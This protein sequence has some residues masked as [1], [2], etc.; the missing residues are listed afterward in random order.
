MFKPKALHCDATHLAAVTI[1]HASAASD[2]FRI[3]NTQAC[4]KTDETKENNVA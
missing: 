4:E 2:F 3:R 1:A